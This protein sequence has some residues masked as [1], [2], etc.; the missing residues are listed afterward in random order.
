MKMLYKKGQKNVSPLNVL[1]VFFVLNV[2]LSFSISDIQIQ[3]IIHFVAAK[4]I[5]TYLKAKNPS[6]T[7]QIEIPKMLRYIF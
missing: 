7:T 3:I 6:N 2:V 4:S 1:N 5:Y